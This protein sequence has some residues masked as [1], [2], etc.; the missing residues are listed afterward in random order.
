MKRQIN[1]LARA[2][3]ID[4]IGFASVDRFR[5]APEGRRP[6]DL[7]AEAKTVISL[8]SAGA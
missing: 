1:D 3:H 7:L 6:T 5:A 4:P 2:N 8:Q